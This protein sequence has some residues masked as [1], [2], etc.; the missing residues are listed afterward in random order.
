LKEP[1]RK[2][3]IEMK[4]IALVENT[5]EG[6]DLKTVHGLSI[7]IETPKH[8]LLFDLGPNDTVFENAAKLGVDL[9]EVDTVVISHGHYDHGASLGKFLEVNDKAKIYIRKQAFEPYF[10][11]VK[12]E[13]K[14]IGLAPELAGNERIVFTGDSMRIDDELFLFSN[15]EI[16][17]DTKGR[18]VLFKQTPDGYEF[19]DFTHEQYLILASEGKAVL[20]SG[21][22]HSGINGILAEALFYQPDICAVFGGFHLYDPNSGESEPDIL[23]RWLAQMLN[24][25]DPIFYTCHCTGQK[26]F[27]LMREIMGDKL[28]YL[29]TGMIVE[30]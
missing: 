5:V 25:Y 9:T 20:F 2:G 1:D 30:I 11:D 28:R 16:S 10:A 22:S 3:Q 17:L 15:L 23:I 6:K 21:C 13:K 8:K 7:Y 12:S 27:D 4:I 14:F 29:S 24:A 26:A 18:N 19:D